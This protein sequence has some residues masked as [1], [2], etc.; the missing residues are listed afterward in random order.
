[1]KLYYPHKPYHVSQAWGNPNPAYANQFDD[2]N[3]KRHNGIDSVT[4][5]F[6]YQ[7]KLITEFGVFCPMEG[8]RVVLV[9]YV[10]Q[11]GG[12]ELWLETKDEYQIGDK[13]CRASFILCHA[14]KVLVKAG[15]EPKLGELLMISDTT[16]FSTGLHVHFGM[17]RIDSRG[18]KID[19]NEA[20]GSYDPAIFFTKEYAVDKADTATH[21]KSGLRYLAYF[22]GK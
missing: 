19:T 11:G 14:K 1:M 9:R 3:F 12:N 5:R 16:G 18:R 7:G 15:D 6:D 21:I 22:L 13:K 8:L 17:Y 20:T 4:N 10:E 2:P